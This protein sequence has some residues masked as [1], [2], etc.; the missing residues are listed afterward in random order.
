[1][2]NGTFSEAVRNI[3]PKIPAGRVATYGRIVSLVGIPGAAQS[4]ANAMGSPGCTNGWHCVVTSRG[5][6]SPVCP[7]STGGDSVNSSKPRR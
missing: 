6:V 7:N 2:P 3:V 5:Q 4:V 1:M